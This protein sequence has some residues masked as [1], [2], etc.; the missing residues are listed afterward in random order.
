MLM[1]LL[2]EEQNKSKENI[3]IFKIKTT[4]SVKKTTK[5]SAL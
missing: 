3:Y 2:R 4:H 5:K 1:F